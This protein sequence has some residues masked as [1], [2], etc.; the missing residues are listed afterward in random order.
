MITTI[1]ETLNGIAAGL[2]D[3]KLS[4]VS[5]ALEELDDVVVIPT[6]QKVVDLHDECV[7]KQEHNKYAEMMKDYEGLERARSEL[8]IERN[9]LREE[10]HKKDAQCSRRLAYLKIQSAKQF[11]SSD[12]VADLKEVF[13]GHIK[14]IEG[15]KQNAPS[16]RVPKATGAARSYNASSSSSSATPSKRARR[17]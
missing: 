8:E 12:T 7:A 3:H 2:Y 9:N 6:S 13:T 1:D 15:L 11:G 16:D 10:F 17:K 5:D 4:T 14:Q